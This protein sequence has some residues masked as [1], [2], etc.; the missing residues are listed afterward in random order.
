MLKLFNTLG[1]KK[2]AF[3]PLNKELVTMY[4]CGL[5]VY[6]YGHI[7]NFRAFLTADIL[8][9]YLRYKGYNVKHVINIT[10]VDD[11]T[12]RISKL[13]KLSL[14]KFTEKYIKAFFEDMDKLNIEKADVYPRATEHIK[15][16]VEIIKKLLEKGIAYKGDD[17]TVY[18][19]VSKFEDYGKLSGIK[20]K[21]LKAG[22]RVSQDE[23][24]KDQA[25]DFALWKAWDEVD[26][27]V[28][29]ETELGK[30]RPG[31]HIE[32]SAM[33]TKYLG[34]PF[35]I[36]TGGEDLIFPHHENEISQSEGAY[37]KEFARYWIHNS[38]LLVEGKKMSKS[39]GN[40][41]TL[42]DLLAKGYD[43]RAIRYILISTHYKQQFNFTFSE[44]D[45]AKSAVDKLDN[46]V[47]R[48]KEAKAEGNPK[49]VKD[50]I[51]KAKLDFG[52]AMDDDLNISIALAAVFDFV[53]EINKIE[54]S[55]KD[56]EKVLELMKKFDSVLGVISF[57]QE[58]V[59]KEI[60]NLVEQRESARK[61]KDFKKADALRDELKAKGYA[62]E[63]TG[64]GPRCKKLG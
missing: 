33:S 51:A 44:L 63:D 8:K 28:F 58:A 9:R 4:T 19:A 56:A 17:R 57:E 2:Q 42:R 47:L 3:R 1:K 64:S 29:W 46:F 39:L 40:F 59:P 41:Y 20:S 18:Y 27:D 15:E 35:D 48:L 11:K 34:Q 24:G 61:Q 45:A 5:T 23:Y 21:E 32:C 43:A 62:V 52:K 12:I 37:D 25:N 55:K 36:H 60:L 10:D 53:R 54:L 7:G 13:Q 50:A 22:A 14:N 38:W 6:D 30:G 31:W 49:A 26:G 16:M